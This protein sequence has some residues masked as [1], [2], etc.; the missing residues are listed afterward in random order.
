M[1]AVVKVKPK[2]KSSTV[3]KARSADSP[4]PSVI[5]QEASS[6]SNKV[7]MSSKQASS[8]EKEIAQDGKKIV[9]AKK[10]SL[11]KTVKSRE[12]TKTGTS[13]A[14]LKKVVATSKVSLFPKP[15]NNGAVIL[16]VKKHKS[17]KISSPL[18][19]QNRV[20][21]T[22]P[23]QPNNE[24]VSEK[25]IHVIKVETENEVLEFAQ[26]GSTLHFPLSLE[27]S[28]TKSSSLP[29]SPA[30][31]SPEEEDQE[32]SE[33]TDSK[34]DETDESISESNGGNVAQ[35]EIEGNVVRLKLQGAY[36]SCQSSV[37]PMKMGIARCLM[38]KI[39]EIGPAGGVT[40]VWV[41]VMQK[42][43]EKIPTIAA[44]QLL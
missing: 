30:L 12:P 17:R 18:K 29:K 24:K 40:T 39:P 11:E 9:P 15:S 20:R 25:T 36:D 1:T 5:K 3:S 8:N 43:R 4:T 23:K 10:S 2:P 42:L 13:I 34:V 31:S 32:E 35:H 6:L 27:L 16:N 28:S 19:D 33:Y 44:V 14:A 41:A 26:N 7:K 37:T 22:E 21:K 38:E